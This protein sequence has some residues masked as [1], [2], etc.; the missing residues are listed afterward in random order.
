MGGDLRQAPAGKVPTFLVAAL[1]TLSARTSTA[2]RSLRA[3]STPRANCRKGVRRRVVRRPQARG[4]R[5]AAAGGQH[6]GC[7]E[8]CLDQ[9]HRRPELITVWKDPAFDPA[10]KAFYYV[11]VIEIPTP[12]WTAY[13]A[14]YY[15]IKMPPEVPMITQERAYTSPIWYT[16]G[17]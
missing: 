1:K 14:R 2:S 5:Q 9:H 4:R 13:D 16:P 12:R 17:Q 6:S 15:G 8:R 11:R 7:R 10:L 3:G